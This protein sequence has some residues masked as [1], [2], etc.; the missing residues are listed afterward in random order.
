MKHGSKR[1][2]LT[3]GAFLQRGAPI[4]R[5]EFHRGTSQRPKEAEGRT[6]SG[7]ETRPFEVGTTKKNRAEPKPERGSKGGY[8]QKRLAFFHPGQ[9]GGWLQ[10][11]GGVGEKSNIF[12]NSP[13]LFPRSAFGPARIF[14]L[15]QGQR[16]ELLLLTSFA[17]GPVSTG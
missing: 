15:R 12:E 11:K 1:A 9:T 16:G 4:Y 3:W 2:N 17:L 6:R 10:Q 14:P 5:G 13:S 7:A 8:P